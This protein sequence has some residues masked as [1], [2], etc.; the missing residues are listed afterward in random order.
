V[1][2]TQKADYALRAM[3]DL[4]L[5]APA[6]G[7]ARSSD[8]A[9]RT[10]VPRKFLEAIL[11]E[12]RKAGFVASKRGPDGGHWLARDAARVT[13]GAILAAIDGPV[14]R[15]QGVGLGA[16]AEEPCLQSLWARVDEAV[17]AV[18]DGVTLEDLRREA[19]ARAVL[20]FNI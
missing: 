16:R 5:H 10:H 18:V 19:G 9:Q 11:L 12:L 7:G 14:V 3:L 17:H 13:V 8:I 4:A 2:I 1:R 20:D 15:G 6:G